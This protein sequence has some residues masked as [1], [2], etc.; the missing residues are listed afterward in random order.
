MSATRADHLQ[1]VLDRPLPVWAA[2]MAGVSS[3][4][5]AAAVSEAGGLGCLAGGLLG[6]GALAE[7]VDAYRSATRAPVLVNLFTP[8]TDR[9]AELG[10]EFARY[11]AELGPTAARHGTEV[12]TARHDHDQFEEKLAHLLDAPV[13]AVT[14]TFG[15]VEPDVVGRLQ[16]VGTA[17][18]FTVTSRHEADLAVALGADFLVAQGA[19][20]GGHR[21]TWHL[22]DVPNEL[23]TAEVLAQ[24]LPTGLPVVA[25]GGVDGPDGVR[26]LLGAGAVA[27][28]V[29]TLFVPS[30]GSRA[31]AAHVAALRDPAR[32]EA[33]VTRAFTGRPARS[34]VN[35]FVREHDGHAP[36]AYP[37]VH[38]QSRP[39]RAASAAAGDPEG[40][41]LWSGSGHRALWPQ[42]EPVV[43]TDPAELTR[44]LAGG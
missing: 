10:P 2:P 29:G 38:H 20:A 12:G 34:L 35:D 43:A 22:S 21:G 4:A 39:I 33:R 41:A 17:V 44:Q 11:A 8:Q 37:D 23:D 36:A 3:P 28:A 6:A 24:V 13:E 9:S 40:I 30:A 1:A 5:L 7:E 19:G 32:V 26:A 27:V 31:S 14:F 15:P 25:T 18:G 16:D 42:A